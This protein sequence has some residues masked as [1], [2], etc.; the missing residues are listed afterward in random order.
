M[1]GGCESGSVATVKPLCTL[2]VVCVSQA[3]ELSAETAD[4]I[5]GNNV[6]GAEMCG[7]SWAVCPKGI[8]RKPQSVQPKVKLDA[9]PK[10]S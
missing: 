10:T 6:S 7:R 4:T 9:D 2:K 3:D 1:L 5:I 8:K